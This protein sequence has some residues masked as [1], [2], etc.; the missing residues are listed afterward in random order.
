MDELK[1]THESFKWVDRPALDAPCGCRTNPNQLKHSQFNC[2]KTTSTLIWLIVKQQTVWN[3]LKSTHLEL[4][5]LMKGLLEFTGL[6]GYILQKGWGSL[7]QPTGCS[8][9]PTNRLVWRPLGLSVA[10]FVFGYFEENP[11]RVSWQQNQVFSGKTWSFS[12]PNHTWTIVLSWQEDENWNIKFQHIIWF[13]ETYSTN[14]YSGN[15]VGIK[16]T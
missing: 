10:V 12:H 13:A 1:S 15:W 11:G 6:W 14:I 7:C 4:V 3:S 8:P 9:S 5:V 16:V 2:M